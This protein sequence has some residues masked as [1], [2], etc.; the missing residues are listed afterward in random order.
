MSGIN[1]GSIEG[2]VQK[3][4]KSAKGRKL[5][6]QKLDEYQ[7]RGVAKTKAGSV[8]MTTAAM[9]QAAAHFI[10]ILRG[11]ASGYF[12]STA[13]SVVKHFNSLYAL[14]PT[15]LPDGSVIVEIWFMDDLHRE[16]LEGATDKNGMPYEGVNNIIALFNNGYAA[17]D[18]VYGG[19]DKHGPTG[20]ALFHSF[21]AS[22]NAHIQSRRSRVGMQF[23]QAAAEEFMATYGTQYGVVVNLSEVY[24][25]IF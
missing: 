8:V 6:E 11:K 1:L 7:H 18:Y 22:S 19:W 24:D 21:S 4:A 5:M 23:M 25:D 2:K 15:E 20:D 16:S 12:A 9:S 14:P 10:S 13:D 17:R 3:F